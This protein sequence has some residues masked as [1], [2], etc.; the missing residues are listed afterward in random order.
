MDAE[1]LWFQ[2]LCIRKDS[3]N[4]EGYVLACVEGG[5][6]GTERDDGGSNLKEPARAA[7]LDSS[8]LVL[9]DFCSSFKLAFMSHGKPILQK[10]D[11]VHFI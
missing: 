3:L 9:R 4:F 2:S 10:W 7:P 11:F 6:L 1:G 8:S 5:S